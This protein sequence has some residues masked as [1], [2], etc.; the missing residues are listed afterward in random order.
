MGFTWQVRRLMSV[1]LEGGPPVV[2]NV[3]LCTTRGAWRRRPRQSRRACLGGFGTYGSKRE[4]YL[5]CL[6]ALSASAGFKVCTRSFLIH[7]GAT[8][9]WSGVP[10]HGQRQ[11]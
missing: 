8:D 7:V 10:L 9:V 11:V 3:M 1:Y 2:A 6:C 5:Q 4:G